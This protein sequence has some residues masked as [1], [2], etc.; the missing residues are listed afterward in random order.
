[1]SDG[2]EWKKMVTS[3]GVGDG[4]T[5]D[6]H[7]AAFAELCAQLP[8]VGPS[9]TILYVGAYGPPKE[10]VRDAQ[11]VIVP[12]PLLDT[13]AA[14]EMAYHAIAG[15]VQMRT[16]ERRAILRGVGLA[17]GLRIQGAVEA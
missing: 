15:S 12:G 7:R 11:L 5:L 10:P 16:D 2:P 6:Q 4:A 17:L 9:G 1:M 8:S 13:L 3:V 14:L